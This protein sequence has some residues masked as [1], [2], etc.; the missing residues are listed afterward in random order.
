MNKSEQGGNTNAHL[1]ETLTNAE[2]VRTINWHYRHT[3]NYL[4]EL[5]QTHRSSLAYAAGTKFRMQANAYSYKINKDTDGD[6]PTIEVGPYNDGLLIGL[7]IASRALHNI[8]Q[9]NI[10]NDEQLA[11]SFE[12]FSI[13][14]HVANPQEALQELKN[15]YVDLAKPYADI[16]KR[17]RVERHY[18][19]VPYADLAVACGYAL[20]G[21]QMMI[22]KHKETDK[23]AWV[24]DMTALRTE[25]TQREKRGSSDRAMKDFDKEYRE[26][27]PNTS[28]DRSS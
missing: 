8:N 20:Y 9:E 1:D 2:S 15:S 22:Q 27:F 5:Q 19:D 10:Y 3:P 12:P 24:A 23:E 17:I 26:H 4:N 28:S 11:E 13:G 7:A 16:L 25:V 18:S 21:A 14:E 6:V